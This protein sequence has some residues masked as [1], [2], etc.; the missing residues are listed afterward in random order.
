MDR[1]FLGI[2]L[3]LVFFVLLGFLG[4]RLQMRAR[5]LQQFRAAAEIPAPTANAPPGGAVNP[6]PRHE[7]EQAQ[8]QR[9]FGAQGS[10]RQGPLTPAL[11]IAGL[12]LG[13]YLSLR[14]V[15]RRLRTLAATSDQLGAGDL[16]VR[17]EEGTADVIGVLARSFNRMAARLQRLVNA[18]HEILHVVSH[19]LR[20]P[21]QRLHFAIEQVRDTDDVTARDKALD[22][23]EIDLTELDRMIDEIL[24]YSRLE[25]GST[26]EQRRVDVGSVV[27]EL[28][29]T[30]APPAGGVKLALRKAF[31][32]TAD[33]EIGPPLD[34][35]LDVAGERRLV[36]RAVSNLISNALRHARS[37]VEVAVR[38]QAGLVQ[39]AVDDDGPGVPPADRER[40]FE[41][42]W[43]REEG[44]DD[45]PVRGFGLGLA[46]V[47]RIAQRGGG[48]VEVSTA[49]TLGGARFVLSLA[50][51]KSPPDS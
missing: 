41:P 21:L 25:E 51:W 37:R 10:L 8:L 40:I 20:T 5:I 27:V 15:R 11:L 42:F 50:E 17:A 47:R 44:R 13:L 48:R 49:P 9:M 1:F 18:Q 45:T 30:L 29:E 2:Y 43:R 46:I 35:P 33:P 32:P 4:G 19:E 26:I 24:T 36:R 34:E 28:S 38:R 39:V 3:R 14:P 12:L 16:A 22:R 23:M 7:I 6:R 31:D